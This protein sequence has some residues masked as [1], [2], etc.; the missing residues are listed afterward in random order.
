MIHAFSMPSSTTGEKVESWDD[1]GRRD[2]E[3][4]AHG[5]WSCVFCGKV[6]TGTKSSYRSPMPNR[7]G[8]IHEKCHKKHQRGELPL[9]LLVNHRKRALPSSAAPDGSNT[10]VHTKFAKSDSSASVAAQLEFELSCTAPLAICSAKTYSSGAEQVRQMRE[11]GFARVPA[12]EE[13]DE[14]RVEDTPANREQWTE[15]IVPGR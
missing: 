8:R 10:P 13:T 12:T 2:K 15:E 5:N 4:V 7:D 9:Q 3:L 1:L 6:G 14:L 11:F